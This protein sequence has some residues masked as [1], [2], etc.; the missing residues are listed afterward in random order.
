MIV[1]NLHSSA[2]WTCRPERR[3]T[4]PTRRPGG[5]RLRWR[6][7][8]SRLSSAGPSWHAARPCCWPR[9][10][11][12][13]MPRPP[14]RSSSCTRSS[15]RPGQRIWPTDR[16]RACGHRPRHCAA[17]SGCMPGRPPE[18]G[19]WPSPSASASS[20]PRSATGHGDLPS[21]WHVAVRPVHHHLD[22][23]ARDPGASCPGRA[24]GTRPPGGH[25]RASGT[26]VACPAGG[27]PRPGHPA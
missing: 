27:H 18:L 1:G 8:R 5:S 22:G 23:P 2:A 10:G 14:R 6:P 4:A 3:C 7:D 20:E 13:R 21:F 26:G 11:S 25:R 12:R 9:Y 17:P 24:R 16:R 19:A 15:T